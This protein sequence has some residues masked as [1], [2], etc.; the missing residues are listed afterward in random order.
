MDIGSTVREL[1]E[2]SSAAALAAS[3]FQLPDEVWFENTRRQE[4]YDVHRQTES[5]ILLFCESDW[6][7]VEVSVC[8]GWKHLSRQALP[9]MNEILESHYPR[10]G[11]ILRA[12]VAKLLPHGTIKGHTDRHPSFAGSHRIHVPLLTNPDVIFQIDGKQVTMNVGHGYE[13]NNQKLHA[14]HN[15]G[16]VA[17][18][19]FIFDYAPPDEIVRMPSD[20]ERSN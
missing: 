4:D 2:V 17:R 11:V 9:V 3:V 5:L 20:D 19:H 10:R 1:G 8:E 13:I 15:G 18:L 14:V 12:M 6:P 16:D 7:E